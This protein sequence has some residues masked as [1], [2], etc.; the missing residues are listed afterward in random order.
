[1]S[2]TRGRGGQVDGGA[3]AASQQGDVPHRV[4]AWPPHPLP[5]A[6]ATGRDKVGPGTRLPLQEPG[7][8]PYSAVCCE[9]VL[10]VGWVIYPNFIGW[11]T[12][13]QCVLAEAVGPRPESYHLWAPPL[14]GMAITPVSQTGVGGSSDKPAEVPAWDWA[15]VSS[16]CLPT[17]LLVA[18]DRCVWVRR[19][20]SEHPRQ[21]EQGVFAARVCPC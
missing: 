5:S 14:P 21:T 11:E 12:Q 6:T 20:S 19:P 4:T 1:M 18:L 8:S 13:V 2:V 7:L 10:C 3:W 9:L 17:F 15:D 16:R